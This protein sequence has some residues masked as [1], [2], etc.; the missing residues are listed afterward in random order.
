MPFINI[1]SRLIVAAGLLL[2]GSFSTAAPSV[3]DN[4]ISWPN[5]G[6]YQVQDQA[7]YTEVCGG[8]RSCIIEPG[9]YVVI[10]HSK[11]ERFND[12]TVVGNDGPTNGLTETL[13]EPVQAS[14]ELVA[15][16]TFHQLAAIN[17]CAVLS[18]IG[19]P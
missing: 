11:G 7:A 15:E 16:K 6:W 14:L 12:I 2:V 9:T 18:R 5:N 13:P 4:T 3:S 10:N 19:E 1:K 8:G 17:R